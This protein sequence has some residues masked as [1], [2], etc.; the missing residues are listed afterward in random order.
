[1][2][3]ISSTPPLAVPA[4]TTPKDYRDY[5]TAACEAPPVSESVAPW[6]P[7]AKTARGVAKAVEALEPAA[8][9]KVKN[10]T[11]AVE[12]PYDKAT[13]AFYDGVEKKANDAGVCAEVKGYTPFPK[14]KE[15]L[16]ILKA[17]LT[18]P[19]Q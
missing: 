11:V 12:V 4:S 19:Q 10:G 9:A 3:T 14:P 16:S 2:A 6:S 15:W 7:Q 17:F 5:K 1:M 18:S 8:S 13:Q